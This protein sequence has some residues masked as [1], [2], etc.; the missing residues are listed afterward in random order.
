MESAFP[1]RCIFV[2][3]NLEYVL[4]DVIESVASK[5]KEPLARLFRKRYAEDLEGFVRFMQSDEVAVAGDYRESWDA[6][7]EGALSLQRG[8]NLRVLL[9]Q[10][11][12]DSGKAV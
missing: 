8:S 7:R 3:C 9:E 4:H 11:V 12:S 5:E 2:S 1:A 10:V 6:V